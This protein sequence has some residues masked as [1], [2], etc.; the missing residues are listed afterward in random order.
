MATRDEAVDAANRLSQAL[1]EA[2]S[3]YTNPEHRSEL[4]VLHLAV[5]QCAQ[6][7]LLTSPGCGNAAECSAAIEQCDAATAAVRR[8]PP[9]DAVYQELR[10]RTIL[11]IEAIKDAISKCGNQFSGA[12]AWIDPGA[13]PPTP[14]FRFGQQEVRRVAPQSFDGAP[15]LFRRGR[16]DARFPGAAIELRVDDEKHVVSADFFR[17][18]VDGLRT[19]VASARSFAVD[20]DEFQLMYEDRYGVISD[21]WMRLREATNGALQGEYFISRRLDGLPH[22]S[23]H[24]FTAAFV[25]AGLRQLGIEIESE[26]GVDPPPTL[27]LGGAQISIASVLSDAGLDIVAVGSPNKIDKAPEGGWS[28]K[29]IEGLMYKTAQIDL[30]ARAFS[31]QVLWVSRSNRAGLLGVMFD[32]QDDY[33]RQSLAVFADEIRRRIPEGVQRDRKLIQTAVHEIGHALNLAHRFERE[34]GRADSHSCMNYDWRYKGGSRAEEFWSNFKFSFDD[35]ELGFIRHGL[36]SQAVPGGGAFHSA[37]YWHEGGGGYSPYVPEHPLP[38]I[39]LEILLPEIHEVDRQ[40]AFGEPVVLG[41]RL[42]NNTGRPLRLPRPILDLKAGFLELVIARANLGKRRVGAPEVFQ[43]IV[44]RCFDLGPEQ[45]VTVNHGASIEDNMNV[46]FGASGFSFAEPGV[47]DV[48]LLLVLYDDRERIE[49][50]AAS[51]TIRLTVAY[52]T[53]RTDMR[54]AQT[55]FSN[56]VGRWL[57]L[58]APDRLQSTAGEALQ[59]A[60]KR[61]DCDAAAAVKP[62]FARTAMFGTA[63]SGKIS[64]EHANFVAKHKASFDECTQRQDKFFIDERLHG[65]RKKAGHLGKKQ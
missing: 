28:E 30:S 9:T 40:F 2:R 29:A 19:W 35:D 13:P 47:Y 44:A 26:E 38:G 62:H 41:V 16:Y 64:E 58:G 46:T 54:L 37:R 12:N 59:E 31:V 27:T 42:T 51:Q 52:P 48:Q 18:E 57:A 24:A 7:L 22:G 34:V 49:R 36:Y 53:S 61:Y 14:L 6:Q 1:Q 20:A 55:I 50:I 5:S 63:R 21:G 8:R 11:A 39:K 60:I 4:S 25:G 45:V 65:N 10:R 15:F 3:A 43:P 32:T 17:T 33:P 23:A 56:D